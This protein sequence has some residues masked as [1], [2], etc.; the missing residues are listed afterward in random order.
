MLGTRDSK[1]NKP[2]FLSLRSSWARPGIPMVWR[3]KACRLLLGQESQ[4]SEKSIMKHQSGWVQDNGCHYQPKPSKH[5]SC[6]SQATRTNLSEPNIPDFTSQPPVYNHV[7][8]LNT[9]PRPAWGGKVSG[10]RKIIPPE[11][12]NPWTWFFPTLLQAP[13]FS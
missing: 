2:R 11:R 12:S 1:T 9:A 4:Y 10:T 7:V 13:L 5:Q 6:S 3:G 8:S